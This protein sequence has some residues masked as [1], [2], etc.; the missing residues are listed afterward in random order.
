MQID[1]DTYSSKE[2]DVQ[3][4]KAVPSKILINENL[5]NFAPDSPACQARR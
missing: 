1:E 3:S 5:H 4:S 2:E